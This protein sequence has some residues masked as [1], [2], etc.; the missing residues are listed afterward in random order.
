MVKIS[1][2]VMKQ[3]GPLFGYV[4]FGTSAVLSSD[5]NE[6]LNATNGPVKSVNGPPCLVTAQL[7]DNKRL[8]IS[9]SSPDLK[10][11]R[12]PKAASWCPSGS[13]PRPTKNSDVG[14]QYEFCSES[15][16]AKLTVNIKSSNFSVSN[17]YVNGEAKLYADMNSNN[18]IEINGES[19]EF[20]TLQNGFTTEV[21]LSIP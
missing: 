11:A 6:G 13:P 14:E 12:D 15:A 16:S 1:R 5:A 20:K 7:V 10:L 18:F 4:I 3:A 21:Q 8:A 9:V 19:I 2:D 17:I